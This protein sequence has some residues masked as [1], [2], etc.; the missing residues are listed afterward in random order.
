MTCFKL[1]SSLICVTDY[2]SKNVIQN[3]NNNINWNCQEDLSTNSNQ[4]ISVIPHVWGEDIT[5]LISFNNGNL[6][7][8][9]LASECIWNHTQ[10]CLYLYYRLYNN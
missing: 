1:K 5:P 8:I 3:L 7:D 4:H 10:V 6:Y 9:V 2:P